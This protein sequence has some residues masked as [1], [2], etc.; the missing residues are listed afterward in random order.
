MSTTREVH[1]CI[2]SHLKPPQKYQGTHGD[3]LHCILGHASTHSQS[4][5]LKKEMS[6]LLLY[7]DGKE[8]LPA[9]LRRLSSK[10]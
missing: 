1:S 8:W 10:L 4:P 5:G 6:V 9:V 2:Q 7:T 3:P